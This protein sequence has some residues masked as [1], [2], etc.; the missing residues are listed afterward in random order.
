M[1]DHPT[2]IYDDACPLCTAAVRAIIKRD[3]KAIFRFA[4]AGSEAGRRIQ[5]AV[6]IDALEE[7]TLILVKSG[8][9]YTRSDA[10][11]EIGRDLNGAGRGLSALLRLLP[12]RLRDWLYRLVA[13]NRQR[14]FADDR[15]DIDRDKFDPDRFLE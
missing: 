8:T 1:S 14:L 3:R 6:G 9:A 11:I 13:R 12:R 4:S 10:L 15:A 7:G 5:R 2:I